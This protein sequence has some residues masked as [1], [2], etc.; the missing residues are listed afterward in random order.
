MRL[1]LRISTLGK[2]GHVQVLHYKK[3]PFCVRMRVP[4]NTWFIGPLRVHMPNGMSIGLV[5][6]SRQTDAQ[7]DHAIDANKYVAI[8]RI[9]C[10]ALRCGLKS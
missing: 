6:T 9:L 1:R 8:G 5:V 7:T 4:P 2:H 10:Y 3:A